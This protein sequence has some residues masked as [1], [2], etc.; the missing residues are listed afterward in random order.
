MRRAWL[1]A[2]LLAAAGAQARA[3]CLGPDE[4]RI[5][6][7]L[8]LPDAIEALAKRCGPVLG[9]DAFLPRQGAALAARYRREAPADPARARKAI[10]AATGQDFSFLADDDSVTALAAQFVEKAVERHVATKDCATVDGLIGLAAPLRADAMAEALLLGLQLS[11]SE[12]IAGV[13]LCR[14]DQEGSRP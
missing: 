14:P 11:G 7:S 8:A 1:L 3:A 6:F 9:R 12:T 13:P 10:E 2:G 5:L 4:Q